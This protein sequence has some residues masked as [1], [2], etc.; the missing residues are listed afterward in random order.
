VTAVVKEIANLIERQIGTEHGVYLE[1]AIACAAYLAGTS[2]IRTLNIPLRTLEPGTPVFSSLADKRG[3]ELVAILAEVLR[4]EG[5]NVPENEIVMAIPPE[6][7]PQKDLLDVQ[8]ELEDGFIEILARHS[9]DKRDGAR[10]ATVC[11]A[12]YIKDGRTVLDPRIGM[13]IAVNAFV[14]SLKT[15][16][17]PLQ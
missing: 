3:P 9:F 10:A 2:L 13:G 14:K 17:L 7:L 6:H 12:Y 1:T 15:V 11:A 5:V 8:R 16:P 4:A